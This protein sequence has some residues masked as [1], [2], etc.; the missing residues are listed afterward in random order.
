MT[1]HP[2]VT[3]HGEWE[4]VKSR[5]R[6]VYWRRRLPSGSYFAVTLNNGSRNDPNDGRW[7]WALRGPERA[8][9]GTKMIHATGT[10]STSRLARVAADRYLTDHPNSRSEP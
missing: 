1:D 9:D 4:A 2:M 6:L 3:R 5:G 10:R 8:D 7:T